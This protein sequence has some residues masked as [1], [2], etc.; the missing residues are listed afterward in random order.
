M[1]GSTPAA[2]TTLSLLESY[3]CSPSETRV[4]TEC[5]TRFTVGHA[6]SFPP[7]FKNLQA[8]KEGPELPRLRLSLVRRRTARRQD[9]PSHPRSAELGS[10]TKDRPRLG[11]RQPKN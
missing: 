1:S 8:Q 9:D 10:G 7:P 5:V 6:Y 4:C 11:I 2:S 3:I